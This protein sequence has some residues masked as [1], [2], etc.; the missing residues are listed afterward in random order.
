VTSTRRYTIGPLPDRWLIG[1]RNGIRMFVGF[2]AKAV[3]DGKGNLRITAHGPEALLKELPLPFTPPMVEVAQT[4]DAFA[5]WWKQLD[6]VFEFNDPRTLP[7]LPAPLS[8]DEQGI[9]DRYVAKARDLAESAILNAIGSGIS[10]RIEDHTDAESVIASFERMDAQLGFAGLLRQCDSVSG[11]D[12]AR[13]GRVLEILETA[14]RASPD[15]QTQARLAGLGAWR[16]AV[17]QLHQKSLNQLIR[18][19]L[20][21]EVQAGVLDFSEAQNPKELIEIYDYGD[22]LHWGRQPTLDAWEAD[23]FLAKERRLA[24]LSAAAGLAHAYIGFAELAR[25]ATDRST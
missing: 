6:F 12:R 18:D 8:D 4:P 23:E 9:V 25:A 3:P 17:E 24:F 16:E 20:V 5:F 11:R 13:F 19:R 1:E 10:V 15:A 14:A 21:R 22:L 2:V 7:P